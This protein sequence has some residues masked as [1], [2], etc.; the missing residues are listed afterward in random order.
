MKDRRE[1]TGGFASSGTLPIIG[2][3]NLFAIWILSLP[4]HGCIGLKM[5]HHMA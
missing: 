2:N 5:F 1:S 3:K 4:E